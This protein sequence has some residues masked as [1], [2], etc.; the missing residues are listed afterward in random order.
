MKNQFKR[1]VSIRLKLALFS[2]LGLV[3]SLQSCNDSSSVHLVN[4]EDNYY[5]L[6]ELPDTEAGRQLKA[7]I[8]TMVAHGEDAESKYQAS[9]NEL[10]KDSTM[11][12]TVYSAYEKFSE[13]KYMERILLTETLKE[14]RT[15]DALNFLNDIATATVPAEKS[16]DSEYSTRGNEVVIRVTAIEGITLLANNENEEARK[17]LLNLTENSDLTIK[18]MAVRGYLTSIKSDDELKREMEV[19]RRKLPEDLQW[20][21]STKST[22]I[23]TVPHPDMPEDFHLDKKNQ[24]KK[25]TPIIKN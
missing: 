17:L 6:T 14:L 9:L 13:N 3:I 16:V 5:E 25:D 4:G 1:M 21:I 10:R 19:F 7:H 18:Q 8:T 12:E 15:T 20:M 24:D 2:I 23:T 11:Y 22:D